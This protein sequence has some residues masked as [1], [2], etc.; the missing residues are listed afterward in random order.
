MWIAFN[1]SSRSELL[2]HL[3]MHAIHLPIT[4]TNISVISKR[5][6]S[7]EVTL[8]IS[9]A[10][11]HTSSQSSRVPLYFLLYLFQRLFMVNYLAV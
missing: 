1:L 4:A 9:L 3:A 10:M 7:F 2:I 6:G 5:L 8:E 11:H